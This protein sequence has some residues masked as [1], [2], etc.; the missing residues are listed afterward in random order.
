MADEKYDQD[1][2]LALAVK[3]KDAWNE[4]RR[5]PAHKDVRVTFAGIDFSEPPRDKID[6]SGFEFGND[7]DFSQCKWRGGWGRA[8]DILQ[9]GNRFSSGQ[10]FFKGAAFGRAA[11]FVG[12]T[13]GS[14]ANF[15]GTAFGDSAIFTYAL[16]GPGAKFDDA[17]FG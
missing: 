3:G 6:F 12:A 17:V 14:D 2:F 5:D 8:G 16:F 10:A 4:W 13:F 1:F 11:S 9:M 15:T 7:G